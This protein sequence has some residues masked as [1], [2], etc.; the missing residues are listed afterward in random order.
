[1]IEWDVPMRLSTDVGTLYF[2]DPDNETGYFKLLYDRCRASRTLRAV[3]DKIPQGDG[4]IFHTRF[5][6]GVEITLAVA[7]WENANDPACESVMRTMYEE[8]VANLDAILNGGGR[9]IWYPSSYTDQR[10]LESARWLA[11]VEI[12]WEQG[13]PICTFT[14]D[15]PFPYVMDLT[16]PADPPGHLSLNG[17]SNAIQVLAGVPKTITMPAFGAAFWPVMQ[18]RGALVGDCTVVNQSVFDQY[19]TTLKFKYDSNRPG[20]AGIIGGD[21]IEIDTFR[22]TVYLNG[23]EAN[24][25][26]GVDPLVTDF[27]YL[28]PGDNVILSDACDIDFLINYAWAVG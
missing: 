21:Y 23:D 20:A 22:E 18:M 25:K 5:R 19:G 17:V 11:P 10:M 4:E 9:L 3:V 24:R 14:I 26:A 6:D 13:V 28:K 15:S 27:F 1:M 7:L 2:N 16:Q 12:T 8:L